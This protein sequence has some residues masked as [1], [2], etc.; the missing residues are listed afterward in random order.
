MVHNGI[1]Y[2]DMQLIAE[3]YD[4]LRHGAGLDVAEIAQGLRRLEPRRPRVVPDR[5]HREGA[6]ARRRGDRASRSSTSSSTRPSRRAPAAG[7]ARTRSSSASRSP[8]SPRPSSP[9]RSPPCATSGSPRPTCSPARSPARA[10]QDASIVDDIRAALYASKVVAYAQ[11]FEQMQAASRK[12][13]DWDLDLGRDGD[14]LARRLHHPRALPQPHPRRL[15]GRRGRQ[16]AHRAV[17]HGGDGS[18]RRSRGGA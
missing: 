11:G 17:L 10:A 15:R 13:F 12:K 2:A 3:S 18:R 7:P 1:E 16:P 5:D 8:R 14:D 9:A 4:L 6:R